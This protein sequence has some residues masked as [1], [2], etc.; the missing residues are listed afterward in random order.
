MTSEV[1]QKI[2]LRAWCLNVVMVRLPKYRSIKNHV[3]YPSKTFLLLLHGYLYLPAPA[4]NLYF[5]ATAPK[6]YLPALAL[7]LFLSALVLNLCL[8]VLQ[9]QCFL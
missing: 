8:P 3:F 5:L 4:L 6:L 2:V 1:L 7:N 9:L